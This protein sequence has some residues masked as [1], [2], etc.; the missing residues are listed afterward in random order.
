MSSRA[1]I[2]RDPP[3]AP[4]PNS[5]YRGVF[6]ALILLE[7]MVRRGRE[8]AEEDEGLGMRGDGWY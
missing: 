3:W 6:G 7:G 8:K 2:D 5:F 4:S 1:G